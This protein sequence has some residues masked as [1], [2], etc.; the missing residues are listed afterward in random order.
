MKRIL[1]NFVFNYQYLLIAL[2]AILMGLVVLGITGCATTK[3]Y[4]LD[5]GDSLRVT[6]PT[7]LR[8]WV[9]PDKSF[10]IKSEDYVLRENLIIQ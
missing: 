6:S 10:T 8:L 2:F 9:N 7:G 1:R 4:Y 3:E 5:A